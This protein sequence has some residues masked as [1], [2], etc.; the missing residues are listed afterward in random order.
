MSKFIESF[1]EDK[2]T[3]Y[4]VIMLFL[5]VMVITGIPL[6]TAMFIERTFFR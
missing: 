1:F 3:R 5:R 4:R 2:E 6:F